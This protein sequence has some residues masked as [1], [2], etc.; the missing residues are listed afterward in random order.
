[1]N[2][3]VNRI[4]VKRKYCKDHVYHFLKSNQD[5][6]FK[7][8]CITETSLLVLCTK[9]SEDFAYDDSDGFPA[10]HEWNELIDFE[11]TCIMDSTNNY[12][13]GY[14]SNAWAGQSRWIDLGNIA[15]TDIDQSIMNDVK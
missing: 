4:K 3:K 6:D 9:D 2:N 12:P 13:A 7:N 15:D 8:K 1:M 5:R 11:G 14:T 10:F